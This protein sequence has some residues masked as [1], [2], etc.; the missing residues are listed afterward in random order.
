MLGA[1]KWYHGQ[2]WLSGR[3]RS[4]ERHLEELFDLHKAV[5]KRVRNWA[6]APQAEGLFD[7]WE[8]RTRERIAVKKYMAGT[9]AL[10]ILVAVVMFLAEGAWEKSIG[11]SSFFPES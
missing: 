9:N 3:V 6:N 10:A 8:E 7:D 5:E 11:D 4:D 2:K 1:L